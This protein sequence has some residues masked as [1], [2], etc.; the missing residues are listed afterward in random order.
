M[1]HRIVASCLR[2]QRGAASKRV[3]SAGNTWPMAAVHTDDG[4]PH[5]SEGLKRRRPAILVGEQERGNSAPIPG[6][7]AVCY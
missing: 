5:P 2:L 4:M 1:P 7:A 3:V 6:S